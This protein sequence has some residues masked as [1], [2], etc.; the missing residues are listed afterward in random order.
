MQIINTTTA[1][2]NGY[3]QLVVNAREL[4]QK[5]GSKQEFSNWIKNRIADFTEGVDFTVDKVINGEN[6]G[7]FSATEYTLTLDTAKHLAMLERNENGKK[8]RQ[9]FIE[10]ERGFYQAMEEQLNSCSPRRPANIAVST[11]DLIEK[12]NLQLIAGMEVEPEVL[13]YVWNI[14]RLVG[15]PMRKHNYPAELE[16]FIMGLAAGE[17][18]RSE[19]YSAYCAQCNCPMTARR[20][21]P[22]VRNIRPCCESRNA[23]GRKV[24]FE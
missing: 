12:I 6:K 10:I 8:I 17:Y 13:R 15:K 4:W 23:Y 11:A 2:I 7:R 5:L 18:V 16:E 3:E 19:V 20:F 14:G 24:V 1:V 21:W 9:Y 22:L